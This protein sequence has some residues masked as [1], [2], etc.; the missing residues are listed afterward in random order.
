[1]ALYLALPTMLGVLG[2]PSLGTF[3]IKLRKNRANDRHARPI[4]VLGCVGGVPVDR[5]LYEQTN[6]IK[7][8]LR[9]QRDRRHRR[10]PVEA[11][12]PYWQRGG[13]TRYR[14]HRPFLLLHSFPVRKGHSH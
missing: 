5:L 2:T 3:A 1:M 4:L 9:K 12:K 7:Q 8:D 13:T 14:V 10:G 6:P 11:R